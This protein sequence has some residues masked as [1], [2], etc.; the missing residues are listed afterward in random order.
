MIS[1]HSRIVMV[2]FMFSAV[3]LLPRAASAH[4]DTMDGPVLVPQSS[5]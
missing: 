4:C 5:L 3:L 2:V 1:G